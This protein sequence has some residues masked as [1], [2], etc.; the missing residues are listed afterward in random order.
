MFSTVPSKTT[1]GRNSYLFQ[2]IFWE[3]RE[4]KRNLKIIYT[5][6][7]SVKLILVHA[8]LERCM[9]RRA[10]RNSI[11]LS[12]IRRHELGLASLDD[13]KTSLQYKKIRQD[14]KIQNVF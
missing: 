10:K 3:K 5:V 13:E 9:D 12:S 14:Y 8:R 4:T 1:K 2:W 7:L 11:T 6:N